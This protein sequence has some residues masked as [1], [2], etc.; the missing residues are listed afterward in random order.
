M[1]AKIF[2]SAEDIMR[3]D[4]DVSETFDESTDDAHNVP[5]SSVS[6]KASKGKVKKGT[7][8]K[9]A[10]HPFYC[11]N[12]PKAKNL[13]SISK[14]TDGKFWQPYD[15]VFPQTGGG[16]LDSD[17]WGKPSQGPVSNFERLDVP[18]DINL[19]DTL[20]VDKHE[21]QILRYVAGYV[22]FALKKRYMKVK[23]TENALIFL[24]CLKG[25]SGEGDSF[26]GY[27]KAWVE[28][29]KRDGLFLVNDTVFMFLKTLEF[30]TKQILN[31]K[32]LLIL[33]NKYVKNHLLPKFL[34]HKQ[35]QNRWADLVKELLN[36]DL[37]GQLL[38]SFVVYLVKLR[39]NA[40]VRMYMEIRTKQKKTCSKKGEKPLRK[41]LAS[42]SK[43]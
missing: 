30:Q 11:L 9:D 18:D 21:E 14:K 24:Q 10:K 41:E 39:V 16:A 43:E 1:A 20:I 26:L 23:S 36:E 34:Q 4:E 29:Q 2:A 3:S 40:F 15:G 6:A 12:I 8:T 32:T 33:R 7:N 5:S 25:M 17:F 38:H 13:R 31:M 35:V 19:E 28:K 27:S 42:E 37:S 22:P